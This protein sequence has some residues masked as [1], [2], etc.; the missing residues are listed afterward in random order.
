MSETWYPVID[1]DRCTGCGVCINH[2]SRGVYGNDNN[3][4]IVIFPV[5]CV[6]GCRGCQKRCSS[7]AISYAGDDGR[8]QGGGCCCSSPC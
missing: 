5:G 1:Y 2:C 8:Q 4:P 6:H 7:G 3:K